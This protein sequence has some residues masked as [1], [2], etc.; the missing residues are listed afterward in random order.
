MV[1][2]NAALALL[3]VIGFAIL[4][5]A[6]LVGGVVAL[7]FGGKMRWLWAALAAYNFVS[8]ALLVALYREPDLTRA[9]GSLAIGVLAAVAAIVLARLFPKAV[10]V[11]GGFLASAMIVVQA[12]GPLLNPAPEWLVL[13]ITVAAGVVGV[14]LALRYTEVAEIVMSALVGAGIMASALTDTMHIDE[15]LR[16]QVYIV[17][18]LVGIG[19]QL[20]RT[21]RA[22]AAEAEF[23]VPAGV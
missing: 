7:F 10:L 13:G 8:K 22:A 15:S 11:V 6:R 3:T 18:A 1:V 2:N 16:F 12:F 21:R 20:W 23:H 4:A 9:I 14:R 5:L 19:F 17:L